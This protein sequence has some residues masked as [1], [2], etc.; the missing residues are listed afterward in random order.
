MNRTLILK[1]LGITPWVLKTPESELSQGTESDVAQVSNSVS[2][3]S[4]K[5]NIMP[6]KELKP[7][8][9][10]VAKSNVIQTPIFTKVISTI[11][12]FGVDTLTLEFN[13]TRWQA[14][15]VKG[16]LVI[17][18][19]DAAAQF[20]SNEPTSAQDL[21][22][23]IFETQNHEG[24]DIPVIITHDIETIRNIPIKKKEVWNDLIMARSV[25]LEMH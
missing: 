20:F 9:I 1:E 15:A 10:I 5:Q 24:N 21:R 2:S 13:P 23:I 22:E 3:T 12:K 6:S 18:F 16:D 11:K 14:E 7:T 17:A 25:Y 19:G 8:W 4:S